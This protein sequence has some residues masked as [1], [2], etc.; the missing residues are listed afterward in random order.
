MEALF[1]GIFEDSFLP[2]EVEAPPSFAMLILPSSFSEVES[3]PLAMLKALFLSNEEESPFAR[4]NE[5][6]FSG[7][8]DSP[9][10]KLNFFLFIIKI[11]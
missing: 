7:G 5:P 8:D 11:F 1:L 6:S 2:I 3:L 10:D 9:L 4:L